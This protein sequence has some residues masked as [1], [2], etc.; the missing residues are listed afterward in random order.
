MRQAGEDMILLLTF[1]SRLPMP[2]VA[3]HGERA[4]GEGLVQAVWLLPAA[5]VLI[6]AP[7][8]L[9]MGLGHALGLSPLAAAVVGAG[10]L[11]LLTGALHEDGLADCAD[12]FWGGHNR[13]RRL[14]I[15]RDSRIG[16][17]GVIAL[18]LALALK[19]ALLADLVATLGLGA[20]LVFVAGAV[21]GRTVALYPWVGLPAAR[22]D[23]VARALGRPTPATFRVAALLGVA[24]TLA[25]SALLSPLGWLFGVAAAAL[26]ATGMARLADA[27]VGGHTGDVIGATVIVSEL[28]YLA[29]MTMC[30]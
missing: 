23:G 12:G 1:Y 11:T 10:A 20:A 6:G 26:A 25:L 27:K 21:A 16:A 8:A 7:A 28:A 4:P 5:A 13:V 9:L 29:A 15:M 3:L 19:I 18:V 2:Q 17:Y 30:L 14:E 22:T 24:V